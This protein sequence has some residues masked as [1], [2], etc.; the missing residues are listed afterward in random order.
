MHCCIATVARYRAHG[1]A[2]VEHC[3][4]RLLLRGR[5]HSNDAAV[6]DSQLC[7]CR[8]LQRQAAARPIQ[9]LDWAAGGPQLRLLRSWNDVQG[10]RTPP[11]PEAL[12]PTQ[13]GLSRAEQECQSQMMYQATGRLL[14]LRLVHLQKQHWYSAECKLS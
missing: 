10:Y 6:Q 4:I 1:C 9:L 8:A 2:A 12:A 13:A 11:L 5:V 7:S 3:S 14:C